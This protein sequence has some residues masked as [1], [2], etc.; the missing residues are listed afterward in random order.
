MLPLLKK[1]SEAQAAPLVPA[2][3]PNFRNYEKLPDIKVVRTAF[4]VN[5]AAGLVALAA[6]SV[7]L[8]QEYKLRTLHAQ[9]DDYNH[10]IELNKRHSDQ[11]VALYK[12]FQAEEA[13]I[14]EADAFV[15][16]KQPI[17]ELLIHLAATL[18]K[19]I[20]L[21]SF[22]IRES[23]LAIKITAR[24]SSEIAGDRANAYLEQ[25]KADKELNVRFDSFRITSFSRN[26]TSGRLSV[27][28][29]LRLK[30]APVPKS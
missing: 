1:K 16:S 19:N 25:L 23:G 21:D 18:P 11:S 17:S 5:G 10:Q 7:F 29:F 14:Q 4:F 27:D 22:D 30:G 15:K 8:M 2:W 20:A 6:L 12:K 24:G 13:K 28:M 26:L 3:H 9:I